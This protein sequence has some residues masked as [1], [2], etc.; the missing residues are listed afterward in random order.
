MHIGVSGQVIGHGTIESV[1]TSTDP[2]M[3]GWTLN[4]VDDGTIDASKGLLK[5]D[6]NING[7]GTVQI[8]NEATLELGGSFGSVDMNGTIDFLATDQHTLV[9]D[10]PQDFHGALTGVGVGDQIIIPISALANGDSVIAVPIV[11]MGGTQERC[12][13]L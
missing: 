2:T 12:T 11:Q 3:P 1:N 6:G 4:V 5:I 13:D 10:D 8:S 7:D 9:L